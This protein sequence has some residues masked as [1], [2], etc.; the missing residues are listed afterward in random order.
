MKYP[1]AREVPRT[2]KRRDLFFLAQAPVEFVDLAR[3]GNAERIVRHVF[4]DGRAGGG[5][6]PLAHG[7]GRDQVGVAADK[8]VVF[9]RRA[10]FALPV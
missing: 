6:S 1:R 2:G 7:N 3:A 4:G 10:E 5:I 8:G 9:N